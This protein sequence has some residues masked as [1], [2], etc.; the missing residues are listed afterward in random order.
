MKNM[1]A[2]ISDELKSA[3]LND[4]AIRG[5]MTRLCSNYDPNDVKD[6][7]SAMKKDVEQQI[8]SS[9]LDWSGKGSAEYVSWV[10]AARHFIRLCHKSFPVINQIIRI[11]SNQRDGKAAKKGFAVGKSI[12]CN[13]HVGEITSSDGSTVSVAFP[14]MNGIL[15]QYVA[16][17][18]IEGIS[19]N[20]G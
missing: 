15:I 2:V 14:E 10:K 20:E 4:D 7:I 8:K 3:G 5:A 12:L 6:A 19:L 9:N 11:R 18:R 13:G 16:P 1:N 17:W